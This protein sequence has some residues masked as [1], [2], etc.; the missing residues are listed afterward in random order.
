[1]LPTIE[2]VLQLVTVHMLPTIEAVLQ[3]VTVHML[4]TIEAGISIFVVCKVHLGRYL[5]QSC[6]A[7][8]TEKDA[9]NGKIIKTFILK[10]IELKEF[11]VKKFT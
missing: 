8:W 9:C 10:E 3:L 2:A 4:P 11:N 1:M 7:N 6:S 5:E